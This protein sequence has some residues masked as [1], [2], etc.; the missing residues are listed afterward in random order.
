[1]WGGG[2]A[3]F[4]HVNKEIWALETTLMVYSKYLYSFQENRKQ[5]WLKLYFK[6]KY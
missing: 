4:I 5:G 6:I 1:M 2:F 3:C